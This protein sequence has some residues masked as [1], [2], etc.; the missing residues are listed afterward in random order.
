VQQFMPPDVDRHAFRQGMHGNML[1]RRGSRATE[2]DW[3][4]PD[5]REHALSLL[6]GWL[7]PHEFLTAL[8]SSPRLAF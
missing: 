3:R 7:S 1:H 4:S 5:S 2:A 6:K 8:D